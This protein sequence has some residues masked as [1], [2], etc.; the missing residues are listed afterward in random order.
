MHHPDKY[1]DRAVL[2]VHLQREREREC[3]CVCVCVFV[4]FKSRSIIQISKCIY[5][6]EEARE[7]RRQQ[8]HPEAF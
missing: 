8:R 7:Q 5:L 4:C 2:K 3:V 6:L 1:S